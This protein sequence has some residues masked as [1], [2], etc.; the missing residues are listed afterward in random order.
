VQDLKVYGSEKEVR[1][2]RNV[3]GL[4][5]FKKTD[6]FRLFVALPVELDAQS[7]DRVLLLLVGVN[8]QSKILDRRLFNKKVVFS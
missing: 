5:N 4:R 6:Q 2:H 8:H 7:L 1:Y 3:A